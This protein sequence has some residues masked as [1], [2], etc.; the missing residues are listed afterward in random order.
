MWAGKATFGLSVKYETGMTV[1]TGDFDFNLVG[2]PFKAYATGFDWLV[3]SGDW[4]RF[5]GSAM[6]NDVD[7]YTFDVTVT[8]GGKRNDRI[9]VVIRDPS[10]VVVYDSDGSQTVK[11]QLTLQPVR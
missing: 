2:A 10:G 7:G 6:V 4:A 3:V 9:A 8:D 11:G 1:P 5:A